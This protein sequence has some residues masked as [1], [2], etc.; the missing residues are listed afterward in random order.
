MALVGTGL[1]LSLVDVR[2]IHHSDLAS[3]PGGNWLYSICRYWSSGYCCLRVTMA[4]LERAIGDG[5]PTTVLGRVSGVEGGDSLGSLSSGSRLPNNGLRSGP[6]EPERWI[7]LQFPAES[8]SQLKEYGDW[9]P[10]GESV[11][12]PY[13]EV[14]AGDRVV[15]LSTMWSRK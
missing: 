2:A 8:I 12:G 9:S 13:L 5:V 14:D 10:D 3:W 6:S 11:V 7:G 15:S 1:V 4:R